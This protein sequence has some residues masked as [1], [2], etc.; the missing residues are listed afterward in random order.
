MAV[1]DPSIPQTEKP[2]RA[3]NQILAP[4]PHPISS[5]RI[6]LRFFGLEN[7]RAIKRTICSGGYLPQPLL[8][9]ISSHIGFHVP[10]STVLL[11]H[12]SCHAHPDYRG[13]LL[14]IRNRQDHQRSLASEF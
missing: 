4:G 7:V 9:K 12:A 13:E 1:A 6:T 11:I 10:T 2:S 14:D 8:R 5:N 3:M